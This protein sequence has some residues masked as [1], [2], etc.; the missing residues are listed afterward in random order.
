MFIGSHTCKLD[1]KGRVPFPAAFRATAA[2]SDGQ[3]RL[4]VQR[5]SS[6]YLMVMTKA[7]GDQEVNFY[8]E[9]LDLYDDEQRQLFDHLL[10]NMEATDLD[11]AGRIQ[12]PKRFVEQAGIG[13]DVVFVGMGSKV[14]LWDKATYDK[15]TMSDD[16]AAALRR[17]YLRRK[18][19]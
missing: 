14:K 12:L 2:S 6:K 10:E 7:E 17:K 3:V 9:T 5:E 1:D 19:K 13:K 11:S 15:S 16:E 18:E 4:V 8:K